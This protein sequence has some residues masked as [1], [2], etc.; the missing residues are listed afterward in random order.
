MNNLATIGFNNGKGL[1]IN[2]RP[3]KSINQYYNKK[4]SE[5]SSELERRNKSKNSKRLNRLTTKRNNK[6]KD[7]LH[8]ASTM[9]V[10][11]LISNNV[12]KVVI[13]KNDGWKKEINIGK[14]NNQ[15]FVNIPHAVFIEMVCYKC[16]LNGIEVVLREES[17]TSKSSFWDKDKIPIFGKEETQV[18]FSGRRIKRGLYKTKEGKILNADVNGALNILRKSNV[19]SLTTLYSRG[20]LGTPIRIRIG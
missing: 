11:Q 5:L 15:N 19:V 13:G 14:R 16:K 18:K 4:K 10:N 17:Y 3:L 7:Y 12:C 8:K 6:V 20:E 2:G 9:L 1:I